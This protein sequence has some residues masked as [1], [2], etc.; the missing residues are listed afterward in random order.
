MHSHN[1]FICCG[2]W[3]TSCRVPANIILQRH[4]SIEHHSRTYEYRKHVSR[5]ISLH[6]L[7]STSRT[8]PCALMRLARHVLCILALGVPA[9]FAV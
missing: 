7:L 6:Q 4:C 8:N 9:I 5:D 1:A 2:V 3:E